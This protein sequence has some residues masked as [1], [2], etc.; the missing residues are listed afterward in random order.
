M[1]EL[2]LGIDDAGRGPVMGPMILCGCLIEKKDEK[3]LKSLG[4]KDSKEVTQKRRE[5]LE[6]K[7]KETSKGFKVQI[8]YPEE[9]DSSAKSG[10]KLNELE[11]NHIAKIINSL[12]KG[13]EKIKVAIDCPSTGIQ[14]WSDYL[15][16]KIKDSSNLDLVVEHK[17]DKNHVA[18]AAASILAKCVREKEVLKIKKEYGEDIGSGY[19]SD[20]ATIKFLEK[21]ALKLKDKGIFRKSWITWKTAAQKLSQQNLNF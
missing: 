3:F 15:R 17:A 11:A 10:L 13:K 16:T 21:N 7:I 1:T 6:E 19:P 5:F 8:I 12:N 2:I 14:K 9:I 20:P 18:A 4:V